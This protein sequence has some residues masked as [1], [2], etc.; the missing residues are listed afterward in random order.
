MT[1]PRSKLLASMQKS[2]GLSPTSGVE[3]MD[4]G[5]FILP[6]ALLL[7]GL[8]ISFIAFLFENLYC[9]LCKKDKTRSDK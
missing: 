9:V 2:S 1:R 3:V 6:N 5:F 7:S 8:A 4:L